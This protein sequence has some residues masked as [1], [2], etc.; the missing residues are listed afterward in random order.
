M[1]PQATPGQVESVP[2]SLIGKFLV[3]TFFFYSLEKQFPYD[4]LFYKKIFLDP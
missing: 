4:L 2:W 3:P 1:L